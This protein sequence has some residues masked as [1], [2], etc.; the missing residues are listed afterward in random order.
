[1]FTRKREGV[2]VPPLLGGHKA[3]FTAAAAAAYRHTHSHTCTYIYTVIKLP[4]Y[5]RQFSLLGVGD[6]TILDFF[7]KRDV[8][9]D[10]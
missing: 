9:L 5:L 2:I 1:M 7:C 6:L 4:V 10:N 8:V 3:N